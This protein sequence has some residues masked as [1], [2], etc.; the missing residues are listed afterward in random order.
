VDF[1]QSGVEGVVADRPVAVFD[2][3]A[4]TV[5][6]NVA[7]APADVNDGGGKRTVP[8]AQT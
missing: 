1:W 3:R 7:S 5:I 4:E 8:Q 6:D 2:A